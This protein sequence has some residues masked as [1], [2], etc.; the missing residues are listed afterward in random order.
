MADDR[1]MSV[2]R[3]F[4][5]ALG[6]ALGIALLGSGVANA[7]DLVALRSRL[8]NW[9][10]D[11]PN[12]LNAPTMVNPCDA[13]KTQR[14]VFNSG[15]HIESAAFPGACLDIES[16]ADDTPVTLLR[17]KADLDNQRWTHQPD[18]KIVS[19]LGPCLNVF[20]GVAN[21]GTPVIAYHSIAGVEDEEW[22]SIP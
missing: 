20:G 16:G 18:G 1:L 10:L 14:W 7:A 11:A 5:A 2:S 9:C 22:D 8:G 17:C 3:G 15:G 19:S 21:P 4:L 6:A 13:S 12:G